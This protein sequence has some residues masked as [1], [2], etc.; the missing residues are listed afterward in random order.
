[1]YL[2]PEER[3]TPHVSATKCTVQYRADIASLQMDND[4]EEVHFRHRFATRTYLVGSAKAVLSMSCTESDDMDVFVQIRKVDAAGKVLRYYNV[5][6]DEME[7]Q[8]LGE[9]QVPLLN[10]YVY[11]GPHGQIRASHRAID[12]SLSKPHYLQHKHESEEKITPGSVVRIETSIWPGGIIFDEGE[13][14]MFKVSG[15]PMYL[16]EFPTLRGQFDT[17]NV[18]NHKVHIG[19]PE[20]SYIEVP[21]IQV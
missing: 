15:H 17:R 8:G 12:S 11:L 3:L 6:R 10:P 7:A 9:D 13:S 18:G 4:S 21:F 19:G 20:A 5:P 14:M 2:A 16:A 1:M